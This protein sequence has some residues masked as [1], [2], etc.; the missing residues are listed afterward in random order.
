MARRNPA[1]L[2]LARQSLSYFQ[3]Y[4]RH[5]KSDPLRRQGLGR[6]LSQYTDAF[7]TLANDVNRIAEEILK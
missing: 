6:L 5:A 3:Q 2:P 7:P 1:S 4:L